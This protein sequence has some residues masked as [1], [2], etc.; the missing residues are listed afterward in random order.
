MVDDMK[1]QITLTPNCTDVNSQALLI[2][3][4]AQNLKEGEDA[5][6][7]KFSIRRYNGRD[8]SQVDAL[9]GTKI[10]VRFFRDQQIVELK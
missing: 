7:Q 6:T 3:D 5:T 9:E 10:K 4:A 8:L 2:V 1:G